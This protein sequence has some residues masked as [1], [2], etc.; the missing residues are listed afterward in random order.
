MFQEGKILLKRSI[1]SFILVLLDR[2]KFWNILYIFVRSIGKRIEGKVINHSD[3][4]ES[5]RE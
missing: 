3:K 4:Y 1:S 5:E 2:K